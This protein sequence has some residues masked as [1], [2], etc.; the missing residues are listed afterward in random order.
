MERMH[1]APH[2]AGARER[3]L[4]YRGT[5]REVEGQCSSSGLGGGAGLPPVDLPWALGAPGGSKWTQSLLQK[6]TSIKV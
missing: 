3:G 2:S 6:S 1:N 4:N 5:K